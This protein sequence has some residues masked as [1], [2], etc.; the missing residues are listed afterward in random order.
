MTF[1]VLLQPEANN[2]FVK[3][4]FQELINKQKPSEKVEVSAKNKVSIEIPHYDQ[5]RENIISD[6]VSERKQIKKVKSI[7]V[8]NK[9]EPVNVASKSTIIYEASQ[10][11]ERNDDL[12]KSKKIL[13]FGAS[14]VGKLLTSIDTRRK[15]S[16]VKIILPYNVK[17]KGET[18]LQ[19]NSIL[20]GSAEYS[21]PDSKVYININKGIQPEGDEFDISAKVMS[22]SESDDGINGDYH[23]NKAEKFITLLGMNLIGASTEILQDRE[24]YTS[25]EGISVLPKAKVKNALLEGGKR[26]MDNEIQE[27]EDSYNKIEPFVTID[28]GEYLI[29]NL[30]QAFSLK[31]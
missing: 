23:S 31:E 17:R 1:F 18:F 7:S 4:S 14:F 20:I 30:T 15:N 27:I 12:S 2:S 22:V 19:K 21:T 29:V 13:P 25:R 3:T 11:V 8:K 26:T 28:A 5:S 16:I 9:A 6:D 10:V 24:V